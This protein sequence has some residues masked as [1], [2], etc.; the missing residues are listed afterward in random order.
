MFGE[1]KLAML[2]Y[3]ID[4]DKNLTTMLDKVFKCERE[5]AVTIDVIWSILN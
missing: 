5:S 1:F 4:M 2:G 3:C